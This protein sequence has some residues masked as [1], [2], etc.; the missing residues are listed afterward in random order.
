MQ[1]PRPRVSE[2]FSKVSLGT[3]MSYHSMPCGRPGPG[4]PNSRLGVGHRQAVES[5]G[6][7]GLENYIEVSMDPHTP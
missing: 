7:Q 4:R 2:G 5:G 3:D 1:G 6:R